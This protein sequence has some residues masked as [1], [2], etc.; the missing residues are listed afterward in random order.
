[1]AGL[2]S[3]RAPWQQAMLAAALAHLADPQHKDFF[4]AVCPGAGKTIGA[5]LVAR[6]L[7]ARGEIVRLF[8]VVHTDHL[9]TQWVDAARQVGLRASAD[10]PASNRDWMRDVPVLVLTYQQLEKDPEAVRRLV[11]DQYRSAVAFDEIH[12]TGDGQ[13]WAEA[14]KTAFRKAKARLHL[15]GTPFRNDGRPIPY[16][17]Y[18]KRFHRLVVDFEMNY[19]AALRAGD[20]VI[21]AYFHTYGLAGKARRGDVEFD[22]SFDD[23]VGAAAAAVHLEH[24]DR[25][26]HLA[27]DHHPGRARAPAAGAPGADG[28]CRRADRR[29]RPGARAAGARPGGEDRRGA[30]G[31]GDR[32]RAGVLR[33]HRR[34]PGERRALDRG[35]ED[36]LGGRGHPAPAR[37][38][39]PHQRAQRPFLVAVGGALHPLRGRRG[40]QPGGAPLHPRASRPADLRGEIREQRLHVLPPPKLVRVEGEDGPAAVVRDAGE[41]APA[42]EVLEAQAVAGRVIAGAD[43][44]TLDEILEARRYKDAAGLWHISDV[45]AARMLRA[46]RQ[47][48]RTE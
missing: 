20:Y 37:G 21:P 46:F 41:G 23:G 27:R 44:F 12:H 18:D 10:L 14:I 42:L 9:R 34:V 15:T 17:R 11:T 6:E 29:Q 45:D 4:A 24:G 32:R 7:M 25:E 22:V 26:P 13:A 2:P 19:E 16:A 8:V 38:R 40:G 36:D 5:L 35:G 30:G 31:A 48:G 33:A 39:V 28:R 43:E 1:M 47:G 3:R